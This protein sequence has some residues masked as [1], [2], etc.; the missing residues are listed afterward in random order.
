MSSFT[1]FTDEDNPQGLT[2]GVPVPVGAGEANTLVDAGQNTHESIVA[3][4]AKVA[5]ALQ[6]KGIRAGA[7]I[8]VTDVPAENV[9]EIAS[10][11]GAAPG[12]VTGPAA[13]TVNAPAVYADATGKLLK[14]PDA[15]YDMAGQNVTNV[16]TVDGRDVAADGVA[17]DAHIAN[18]SN[19][20][21]TTAAQVGADPA[22]SASAVQTN[23]TAHENDTGN[24]HAT[25]AAQVGADPAGTA[26]AAV[27]A[28]EAAFDHDDIP[29]T[30]EKSALL[31]TSG[32]PS[33]AN[34]YVTDGDARLSDSRPPSGAAGGDLAGTYPNPT[35]PHILATSNPHSVTAGQV[36][37]IPTAE[38]GAANGVA[39]LDGSAEVPV[40][41]LPERAKSKVDQV[42][43]AAA[44]LALPALEGDVAEQLD[45]GEF[46]HFDGTSWLLVPGG[47]SVSGPVSSG[48]NEMA[49]FDG[50][51]G[52]ILKRPDAPISA[53]GQNIVSVG[54]VDGRNLATDGA[55]LDG[56]EPGAKDDQNITAGAGL[57]GGGTGDVA[58]AVDFGTGS[59][60][61][62]EGN[63]G[64]IPTQTEN[65]ALQGTDGTPS[66]A[67][68]YVTDSDPRNSDARAPTSHAASHQHGGSDEVA[69]ASPA[70][71]AIV[72]ANAG[73][74]FEAGWIDDTSHGAR[75]GGAQHA[76]AVASVSGVGGANGFITAQNQEKLDGIDAGATDNQDIIAGT[77]LTGGGS[78]DTVNVAA[79]IG[80]GGSQVAA[81][82]DVRFPSSDE[83]AAL[84]GTDG[85]PAAGNPYVT[86]TDSRLSD[87]RAPTGVASGQLGGTYPSPEVRGLR[88][89]GGPTLL[90]MG[91][92]TDGQLL[93]RSG[94]SI[95]GLTASV[96]D[97][98]V[99]VTGADTTPDHLNDKLTVSSPLTKAVVTPG[100][101]E[102]LDLGINVGTGAGD[103]AVG[104][105]ARFPTTDE[106]A[107]L[108]GTDGAPSGA[109]R[110]V[111]NSD[112]RNSDARAP[113]AHA[114][115]HQN[116]GSDEIATATPGANAIPKA[117]AGGTLAGGWI[118]YGTAASTAAEG[119]DTRI[120]TQTEN[121]A[122]QGTDGTPSN[123][124][125][126]VTNSDSR[127]SD[128][129]APNGAA[130]GQLG[131][132]YPNPDVRGI[133][134]TSG[135]TLLTVGAV[136]DGEA[137]V[138]SGTALVGQAIG[139]GVKERFIAATDYNAN[140]GDYRARSVG[141]TGNQRFTFS[142]P[143]DFDSLV[144]IDLIGIPN[145][146]NAAADIDISSEY[147][148]AG[149]ASDTHSESDT[150]STYSLTSGNIDALDV[151]GVF[152]SLA[153]GD[154]CGLFVDHQG[155]GLTVNYLGIRL[156]YNPT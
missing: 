49:I 118:T 112:S 97:E 19:P 4:P 46:Y 41:Q 75:G 98:L 129:R 26:T 5:E 82:N 121:D 128:S 106:N 67:N 17:L 133:R 55:K 38:K 8:T 148:A 79:D 86:D 15:P 134:E 89:S 69:Q 142:V 122:L 81:G 20:H 40:A 50:A 23:L 28:H 135:P 36:G 44:R 54:T 147:A 153:A 57:S 3:T 139:G 137:L 39:S 32:A 71:N 124:N 125:R 70:A 16:G 14:D 72:K 115:S 35:V 1:L 43:N 47:G 145:G 7:G 130:G 24:P 113:T 156:R 140:I 92:V 22:G 155:L 30:D 85:T 53:N 102:T 127:N 88:E 143:L 149:Q 99:G 103:V 11:A 136:A 34:R 56:I 6:A 61:A 104:N 64:R 62:A 146:T 68:R 100:G 74:T 42:A 73:G 131:G 65:D 93:S 33:G 141:S 119:D 13:S 51:T 10:T 105:D 101:N 83:K 110:Y 111:T 45:T 151:S 94:T 152:S 78:G 25:T 91:A 27:A 59:S 18:L 120:P 37:A 2:I 138:R 108:A 63:D 126:Y 117:G 9:L 150:T 84:V 96:G 107:A 60:Q 109:N 154:F 58:L 132:T 123:T 29:T 48:D 66:N 31:G 95:V 80:T 52:K 12:D 21:A 77:G 87:A 114:A 76:A 144:A 116:G 90:S